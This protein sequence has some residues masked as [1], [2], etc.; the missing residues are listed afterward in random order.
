LERKELEARARAKE[1]ALELELE[2]QDPSSRVSHERAFVQRLTSHYTGHPD[3]SSEPAPGGEE[4][5]PQENPL[6]SES[7]KGHLLMRSMG[8]TE[9]M[10]LGAQGSGRT[11]AVQATLK[12]DTRG[13]GANAS[14]EREEGHDIFSLYQKRLRDQYN[15]R[16][17][18][19]NNPRRKY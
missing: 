15:H 19:M 10:G 1:E 7:N 2:R 13:L 3:D 12:N 14:K 11:E 4:E 9:G 6:F 16:P 8:W 18:P 5:T 17:N